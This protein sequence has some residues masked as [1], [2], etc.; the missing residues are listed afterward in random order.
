MSAPVFDMR[1]SYQAVRDLQRLM[2]APVG[3]NVSVL[4]YAVRSLEPGVEIPVRIFYPHYEKK[5]GVI[6]YIHGGGWVIGDLDS[7]SSICGKLAD[8]LGKTVFSIDYSLAPESPF[9][10]GLEDCLTVAYKIIGY[11]PF[12]DENLRGTITLMGDSAGANL[13]LVV[14]LLLKEMKS[15]L[16]DNLVLFYPATYWNHAEASSPFP[17]IKEMGKDYGLT[18]KKIQEYMELYLPDSELRKRP[19]VAP[20]LAADLSGLPKT[21]VLTSEYDPLRDEGEALG[22]AMTLAGNRVITRRLLG[23]PHGF[24]TY[25]DV[26]GAVAESLRLVKDFQDLLEDK[27]GVWSNLDSEKTESEEIKSRVNTAEE[28]VVLDEI[29][30]KIAPERQGFE[31]TPI[32][33]TENV[34]R[35]SAEE[36]KIKVPN[37]KE[38]LE[39]KRVPILDKKLHT[40]EKRQKQQEARSLRKQKQAERKSKR[41]AKK[42]QQRRNWLSLDNASKIFPATMT[43]IDTKVF[44][45]SV[46]LKEKVNPDI[47]QAALDRTY[48]NFPLYHCVLRRGFF[49]Y[50]FQESRL[51]PQVQEESEAPVQALYYFDHHNLLFRVLYYGKRI[52]LE[53]FHALSDGT[54]ALHFMQLLVAA[55]LDLRYPELRDYSPDIMEKY[56]VSEL[57]RYRQLED[58]FSRYFARPKHSQ[59]RKWWS[60]W[61]KS[62]SKQSEKARKWKYVYRIKGTKTPDRR[63]RI[64]E[65]SCPVKPL[66][67]EARSRGVSLSEFLTAVFI[68]AIYRARL[69][70]PRRRK[71]N[72]S[73]TIS[74]PVNLRKFFPSHSARNFF[75]TVV[76]GYD[77]SRGEADI[78]QICG[79]ISRQYQEEITKDNLS[80]KLLKLYR[81]EESLALRPIFRP[82]K[83]FIL[84]IFYKREDRRVTTA[85]SN[86]GR[87]NLPEELSDYVEQ[88]SVLTAARRPQFVCLTK[89]EIFSLS[90]SSPFMETDIEREFIRILS[91][92]GLELNLAFNYIGNEDLPDHKR[93]KQ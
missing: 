29:L 25:P 5:P 55:Y 68:L 26:T 74:V 70:E 67:N 73:V 49:W 9:P 69:A 75:T 43:D 21:L 86:M 91:G 27:T 7:Y 18:S 66:L 77:F 37:P 23:A 48:A 16:A 57:E 30:A 46:E 56:Q 87:I 19:E 64:F 54:G 82:L 93:Y 50:Y 6:I 3:G 47:L 15:E 80:K 45:I 72:H 20:L 11:S 39:E 12:L 36:Q 13:A 32:A 10:K 76:V 42:Q 38:L 22:R 59:G 44:R 24:L 14:T 51:K 52:H 83:D 1:K 62:L 40:E 4:D 31:D 61:R 58:S 28:L 34:Q 88:V 8:T 53:V 92:L 60:N 65:L 17:S 41:E 85:V 90:F 63:M 2:L 79:A 71:K 78:D 33:R 35:L 84:K 89:D 81:F